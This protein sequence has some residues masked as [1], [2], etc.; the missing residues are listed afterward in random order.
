[1]SKGT[2]F[3]T[4]I[5]FYCTILAINHFKIKNGIGSP[6]KNSSHRMGLIDATDGRGLGGSAYY[7]F[8]PIQVGCLFYG[9]P[10]YLAKD[11]NCIYP[12]TYCV[13]FYFYSYLLFYFK[14]K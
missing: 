8:D 6:R 12:I 9:S 13:I 3:L 4:M 14:I 11:G 1:M 5:Q 7:Y 2:R 10:E